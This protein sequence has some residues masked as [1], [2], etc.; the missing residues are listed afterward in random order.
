MKIQSVNKC[1][2]RWTR[3]SINGSTGNDQLL[4]SQR[5]LFGVCIILMGLTLLFSSC[6]G[7]SKMRTIKT[8]PSPN[9]NEYKQIVLHYAVILAYEE[10]WARSRRALG[11]LSKLDAV[12]RR[13]NSDNSRLIACRQTTSLRK[14]KGNN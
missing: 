9:F 4:L 7:I 6:V 13:K 8:L 12:I 5:M 14:Q 1:F 3:A 2:C 10:S 11:D